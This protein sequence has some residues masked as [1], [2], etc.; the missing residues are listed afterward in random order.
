MQDKKK[1]TQEEFNDLVKSLDRLKE[2]GLLEPDAYNNAIEKAKGDMDDPKKMD[3]MDKA[4]YTSKMDEMKK[5]YDSKMED[6]QKAMMTKMEDMMKKAIE[7]MKGMLP[8]SPAKVTTDLGKSEKDEL[9]KSEKDELQKSEKDELTKQTNDDLI[10]SFESVVTNV[11]TP[12]SKSIEELTER[13][14]QIAET[15]NPFKA[16]MG[17]YNTINKSVG[18]NDK[19]QK[20]FS[21]S[22]HSSQI[23]DELLKAFDKAEG[24]EK[25]A[26]AN[27]IQTLEVRGILTQEGENIVKSMQNIDIEK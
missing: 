21:V 18:E 26:L 2:G 8:G 16:V 6:M 5:A 14:D 1:I 15:P 7:D 23:K 12:V 17:E 22:S 9:Q 25:N 27:A 11:L 10:K 19:G 4:Y 3:M 20:V 13:V 24:T